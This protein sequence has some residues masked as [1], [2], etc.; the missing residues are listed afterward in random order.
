MR[1]GK[2]KASGAIAVIISATSFVLLTFAII[3]A[4]KLPTNDFGIHPSFALWIYSMIFSYFSLVF[5]LIDACG[6]IVKASKRINPFF[7]VIL[8]IV[9][10]AAV[11]MAI[12]VGGGI[13]TAIW[14]V[15]YA[16]LIVLEITSIILHKKHRKSNP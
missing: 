4:I 12:Y 14:Y 8:A 2:N 13:Y 7:N 5:Y 9:A 3:A 16:F 6:A 10:F 15:Y 11:P 1:I